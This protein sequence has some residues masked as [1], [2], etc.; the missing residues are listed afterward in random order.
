M[1]RKCYDY[2]VNVMIVICI[3]GTKKVNGS[4]NL[5]LITLQENKYNIYPFERKQIRNFSWQL[6]ISINLVFPRNG[7]KRFSPRPFI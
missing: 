5:V 6:P 7:N 4:F 3:I 2:I 1:V